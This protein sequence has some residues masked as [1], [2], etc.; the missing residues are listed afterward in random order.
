[1]SHLDSTLELIG[2]K[3]KNVSLDENFFA[4][5]VKSIAGKPV[6]HKVIKATLQ[7]PT[8][9]PCPKCKEKTIKW[10][11]ASPRYVSLR[12]LAIRLYSSLPKPGITVKTAP[13]PIL[14]KPP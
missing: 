13:I 10:E 11:R 12:L 4:T 1:M 5:E 2:I 6:K 8:N 7:A 9:P 3:D 14:L